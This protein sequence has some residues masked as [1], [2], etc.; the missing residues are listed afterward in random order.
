MADEKPP[1]PASIPLS[2]DVVAHLA[3]MTAKIQELVSADLDS[4]LPVVEQ[5]L[6]S[7]E[8]TWPE[9]PVKQHA[10]KAFQ[11]TWCVLK[12]VKGIRSQ[13]DYAQA[14]RLFLDAVRGFE[15]CGLAQLRDLAIGLGV[16]TRACL[17][18]QKKNFGKGVE[19]L[20]SVRDYLQRA[21][22][23]GSRFE[24]QIDQMQPDTFFAASVLAL[25]DLDYDSFG[26]LVHKAAQA[27]ER[28]AASHCQAG[29]A[30]AD[31]FRGLAEYHL[32]YHT[33]HV[34]LASFRKLD[35]DSLPSED[36]LVAHA[37]AA[38]E[39]FEK[40]DMGNAVHRQLNEVSHAME[41][42]QRAIS[43]GSKQ[44]KG[45]LGHSL[46]TS[47]LDLS[48]VKQL[49]R[50]SQSHFTKAGADW[51][52]L[53][54]TCEE[55]LRLFENAERLVRPRK[56]DFGAFSGVVSCGLFLVLLVAVS[57]L[58]HFAHLHLG[59]FV[60]P[61]CAGL[62]LAGGFGYGAARFKWLIFGARGGAASN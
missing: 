21:G 29:S 8:G 48:S 13:G 36:D 18:F 10:V 1:I 61:L 24:L 39:L 22:Q 19:L 45:A 17:E 26:V 25:L 5:V 62:A 37:K 42:L 34:N 23:Y 59:P 50:E 33:F 49:V 53:V 14:D 3:F 31:F 28:Y 20:A 35:L 47:L 57:L 27:A 12:A 6:K 51:I 16:Y 58:D 56:R 55:L 30:D 60:V 44:L 4:A 52:S 2:A 40:G 32:A 11:S 54:R 46:R 38:S 7:V 15:E 9:N 41:S 43:R